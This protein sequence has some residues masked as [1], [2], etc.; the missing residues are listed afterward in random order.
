MKEMTVYTRVSTDDQNVEQQAAHVVKQFEMQE[1]RIKQIIMD[2][3]SGTLP[4][5]ERKAFKELLERVK[6]GQA[7]EAVGIFKLDRLT[8]NWDDEAAIE[9]VFR[10]SWNSCRLLSAGETIDLSNASG[11]AMFRFIM[12]VNCLMPEDMK[13][14]QRIGIERAKKEGKYKGEARGRKWL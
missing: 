13:E 7:G 8:R 5:Q 10:E 11:R 14:K 2:T 6:I 1:W 3:E 12:V 9:R 4:L